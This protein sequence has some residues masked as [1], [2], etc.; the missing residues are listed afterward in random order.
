MCNIPT[1]HNDAVR[2]ANIVFVFDVQKGK[3]R[4]VVRREGGKM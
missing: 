2:V 1:I 4:E 3:T